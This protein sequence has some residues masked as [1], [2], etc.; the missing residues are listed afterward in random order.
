M[1]LLDNRWDLFQ[2]IRVF[3]LG[4]GGGLGGP[5][6]KWCVKACGW[7]AWACNF[8]IQ[9]VA[10]ATIISIVFLPLVALKH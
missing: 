9:K 7:L 3:F 1:T 5:C 6:T 10:K 8:H 4:G 2:C